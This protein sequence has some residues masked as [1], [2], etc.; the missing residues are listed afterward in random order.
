MKGR[1]RLYDDFILST[2]Q[3]AS[4]KSSCI[5]IQNLL[6]KPCS[7]E[8]PASSADGSHLCHHCSRI[9]FEKIFSLASSGL[10]DTGIPVTETRKDIDYKCSFCKLILS[11]GHNGSEIVD[12]GY[13][14]QALD[15]IKVL[16]LRR[17]ASRVKSNPSIVVVAVPEPADTPFGG[18]AQSSL[19]DAIT[20][21]SIVPSPRSATL[22]RKAI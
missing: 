22:C 2:P 14:L 10:G 8:Q 5:S 19:N 20:R 12:N 6:N 4:A 18:Q 21:G 3:D 1:K 17:S 7:L 13:H 15:S 16:K 9:D 11:F